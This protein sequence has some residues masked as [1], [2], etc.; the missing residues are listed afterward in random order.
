MQEVGVHGF[1]VHSLIERF[2][3]WDTDITANLVRRAEASGFR[4]IVL[5]VDTPVLGRREADIRNG[6]SLPSHLQLANFEP[7]EDKSLAEGVKVGPT[8]DLLLLCYIQD[9]TFRPLQQP[10]CHTNCHIALD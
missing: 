8:S 7:A 10:N 5:T 9:C 1:V 4:A 2:C 6:F 3:L